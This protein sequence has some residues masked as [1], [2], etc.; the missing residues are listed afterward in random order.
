[1]GSFLILALGFIAMILSAS[2]L[3]VLGAP[4][5]INQALWPLVLGLS[6][7]LIGRFRPKEIKL[8]YTPVFYCLAL[9][10]LYL[11]ATSSDDVSL[12]ELLPLL[13]PLVT[14]PVF[15]RMGRGLITN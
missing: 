11:G 12:I 9:P 5:E 2:V 15:Y 13:L 8:I 6:A 3:K 4:T 14:I 1:M 10:V 7:Y